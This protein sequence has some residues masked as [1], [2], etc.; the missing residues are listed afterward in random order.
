MTGIIQHDCHCT[1]IPTEEFLRLS[2]KKIP[3]N[4][5]ACC[6]AEVNSNTTVLNTLQQ[7]LSE[8]FLEVYNIRGTLDVYY[9]PFVVRCSMFN[10]G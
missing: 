2:D 6:K 8:S 1:E 10:K 9:L 5:W 4:W 3:D 7:K